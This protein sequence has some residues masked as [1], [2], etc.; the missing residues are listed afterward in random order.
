MPK[1]KQKTGKENNNIL[2]PISVV[3]ALMGVVISAIAIYQ[4]Q[5]QDE[6]IRQTNPD[7]VTIQYK[8]NFYEYLSI[9]SRPP[10]VVGNVP[11]VGIYFLSCI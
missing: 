7:N 8:F 9:E 1:Q 3:I 4:T 6:F 2:A 5:K 10:C 11:I